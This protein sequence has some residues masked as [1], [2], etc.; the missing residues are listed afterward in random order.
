[1]KKIKNGLTLTEVVMASAISVIVMAAVYMLTYVVQSAWK[2][3]RAKS[4]ITGQLEMCMERIQKEL[5]AT[6]VNKI[7]YYPADSATH[8]A[9]SF[10][11]ALDNDDDGFVELNASNQIIWDQ[12]VIYHL[13][14]NAQNKVELRRTVFSPRTDLTDAQRQQQ[15][16]DVVANGQPI[17]STPEYSKWDSGTGTKTLCAND[18]IALTVTP[19]VKKFD[20]YGPVTSRS[21][22]VS[23]GSIGLS[24]GDHYITFTA[25]DK[26]VLSTGYKLGIDSFCISPSGCSI[27]AEEAA[28]YGDNGAS[29]VNEEMSGWG[30]WSGNRQLEYQATGVDD[31]ISLSFYYD[32]WIETNFAT[33]LPSFT[34]VEYDNKTGN[35]REEAGG[36][37]YVVRLGGCGDSWSAAAQTGAALKSS[38]TITVASSDGVCFRNVILSSSIDIEGRAAKITFDNTQ[39][40]GSITIDYAN[41]MTRT[42]GADADAS[43]RKDI[44]FYDAGGDTSI[45]IPAGSSVDSDWVDINN[46]DRSKDYLLTF[47]I[48]SSG[49]RVMTCWTGDD[50]NDNHSYI[51]EGSAAVAGY[52]VWPD[53]S[54]KKPPEDVIYSIDSADASFFSNGTVTSQIY[55]TGMSNP[56]YSTLAWT[57]AKNNYQDYATG[58]LGANLFIK[59]RSNN[60]KEALKASTDWSSALSINTMSQVA[61]TANIG[62]IG[63]GRYVQF[64]GEFFSQPASGQFNYIKSCVLKNVAIKWPGMDKIVDI[65]GYFTRRP[66]Y[67][68]FS[69]DI[70]GHALTKGLEVKIDST[71]MVALNKTVT[72][73]LT[74]EVEPRNT[75]R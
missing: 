23:F 55:D 45:T 48:P 70:D 19:T 63:N 28:V 62:A 10:P 30:S 40:A 68:I 4:Y 42:N 58:G 27:E 47:H 15:L 38:E 71:S 17:S 5:R 52:E 65:S 29:K 2:S 75:G 36:N 43:T 73:S 31:Y 35:D 13:Y 67:G 53:D 69:V 74:I 50:P 3:E 64:Q 60:D 21:E 51:R 9:I 8:T 11:L 56:S 18:S 16:D 33:S 20:A 1:M 39:G 14:T 66:D 41:I 37:D 12:A 54:L 26:N 61:G 32:Q 49:D 44:T 7:F 72:K 34:L 24:A 57:L 59:A 25:S 6:D 46:F 22:N